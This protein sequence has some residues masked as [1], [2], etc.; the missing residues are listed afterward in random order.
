MSLGSRRL[1][2][3]FRIPHSLAPRFS[4]SVFQRFSFLQRVTRHWLRSPSS[5]LYLHF[6]LSDYNLFTSCTSSER[7]L[8]SEVL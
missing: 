1:H 5:I 3:A 6:P 8:V 2:S 4:F 7:K